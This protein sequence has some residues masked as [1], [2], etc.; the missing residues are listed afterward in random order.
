MLKY[1]AVLS[2]PGNLNPERPVQ[3]FANSMAEIERWAY[4]EEKGGMERARGVLP[5]AVSDQAMVKV[6]LVSETQ[7]AMLTKK[8]K[9]A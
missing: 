8:G 9:P 2:D 7:I 6:Y 5:G 4:G 1:R 3:T